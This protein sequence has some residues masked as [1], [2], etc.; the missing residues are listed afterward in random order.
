MAGGCSSWR[1]PLGIAVAVVSP[2]LPDV[3]ALATH[4]Q[5]KLPLRVYAPTAC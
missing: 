3:S 5:P 1:A 4:Y 2:Q